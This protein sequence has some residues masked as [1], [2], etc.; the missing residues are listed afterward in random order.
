MKKEFIIAAIL[1]FCLGAILIGCKKH[2]ASKPQNLPE[3][4]RVKLPSGEVVTAYRL[5][6]KIPPPP[7]GTRIVLSGRVVRE[8]DDMGSVQLVLI[9]DV[10]A[11]YIL[12]NAPY[13]ARLEKSSL[14]KKAK[15][16]GIIISR[17]SFKN[18]PAIYIKDILEIH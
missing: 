18:Y 4:I 6:Q 13:M 15:I 17:T 5:G 12:L 9:S 16:R 11:K 3:Q 1:A 8:K 7:S 2:A 14:G 10:G